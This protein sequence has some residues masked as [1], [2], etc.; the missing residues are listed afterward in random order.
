MLIAIICDGKR[1]KAQ[2]TNGIT[3]MILN[4]NDVV[5]LSDAILEPFVLCINP[6]RLSLQII[7]SL[8]D[9]PR[10]PIRNPNVDLSGASNDS[11]G[12]ARSPK[13]IPTNAKVIASVDASLVLDIINITR[14]GIK[15]INIKKKP[16][17]ANHCSRYCSIRRQL[18][19]KTLRR[20]VT[21]TWLWAIA[22]LAFRRLLNV[23]LQDD[24]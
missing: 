9:I 3:W 2:T 21:R 15:N 1:T 16:I 14:T 11:L 22:F 20:Q 24:S 12:T 6:S 19:A 17:N 7:I 5:N 18:T 13:D 8:K 23:V 4:N 10:E